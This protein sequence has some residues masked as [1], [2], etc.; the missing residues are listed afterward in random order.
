MIRDTNRSILHTVAMLGMLGLGFWASPAAAQ[1]AP[2]QQP[3][4]A[5]RSPGSGGSP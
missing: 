4:D 3:P 2:W 1:L 5:N